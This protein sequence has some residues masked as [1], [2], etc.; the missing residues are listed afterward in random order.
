MACLLSL[1]SS[2]IVASITAYPSS[3]T[4]ILVSGP[5]SMSRSTCWN[6]PP[7]DRGLPVFEVI[8][9]FWGLRS[10][11]GLYSDRYRVYNVSR[12]QS[13]YRRTC[14]HDD[15]DS[16]VVNRKPLWETIAGVLRRGIILGKLP[17]GRHLDE[18]GLAA[19][20]SV[21]RVPVKRALTKLEH[22]GLVVGESWRGAYVAEVTERYIDDVYQCRL[23]IESSAFRLAAERIDKTG[24]ER[25]QALTDQ[26]ADATRR[27]QMELK[28]EH[29]ISFHREVLVISG[30]RALLYSWEPHAGFVQALISLIDANV[31]DKYSSVE[32]HQAVVDALARHDGETVE[33]LFR[34]HLQKGEETVVQ[35][36]RRSRIETSVGSTAASAVG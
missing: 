31:E 36:F 7:P 2:P 30:N 33:Q 24:I 27:N 5:P 12:R 21:S 6:W 13:Y 17:A 20:F 9:R 25:L 1:T 15:L 8:F 34:E 26:M 35:V 10:T 19:R 22:E 23:M 3:R 4:I 11:L 28:A 14:L 18:E 32:N 16:V 29:D